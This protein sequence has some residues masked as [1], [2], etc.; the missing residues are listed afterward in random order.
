MQ[1]P[2]G[3]VFQALVPS[4]RCLPTVCSYFSFGACQP[5]SST[6]GGLRFRRR[7]LLLQRCSSLRGEGMGARATEVGI[8]RAVAG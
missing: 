4:I 5:I 2:R 3:G 8:W 6:P 1:T 7:R